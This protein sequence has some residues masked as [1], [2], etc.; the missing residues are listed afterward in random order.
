[1]EI[2]IQLVGHELFGRPLNFS[3][4]AVYVPEDGASGSTEGAVVSPEGA[5]GEQEAPCGS[6]L[7]HAKGLVSREPSIAHHEPNDCPEGA[8]GEQEAPCGS[9][10]QPAKGLVSREPSITHHEPNDC[11]EGAAGSTEGAGCPM[12][13]PAEWAELRR[14]AL[15]HKV[16]TFVWDSAQ[17]L[18][19]V[20]DSF[21]D[22]E[23]G[24]V[25]NGLDADEKMRWVAAVTKIEQDYAHLYKLAAAVT[26]TL[27]NDGFRFR[28]LKGIALAQTYPVPSHRKFG[29]LDIYFPERIDEAETVLCRKFGSAVVKGLNHHDTMKVAGV[30]LELHRHF[31]NLSKYSS[32]RL[33]QK[34]LDKLYEGTY[35]LDK[36]L[37]QGKVA[38]GC[39]AKRTADL[40]FILRHAGAHFVSGE[41]SLMNLTDVGR[42]LMTYDTEIDYSKIRSI[43]SSCGFERWWDVVLSI[44]VQRIGFTLPQRLA[45]S[46]RIE[47]QNKG[48]TVRQAGMSPERQNHPVQSQS[49]MNGTQPAMADALVN[50]VMADVLDPKFIS[51]ERSSKGIG[52]LTYWFFSSRWKKRLVFANDS[53]AAVFFRTIIFWFRRHL[54]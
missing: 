6:P 24:V 48:A 32:N 27:K 35:S 9:P 19:W 36:T 45:D 18:G 12:K 2:M 47:S 7:Q 39:S 1:M 25:V 52:T 41:L 11:L 4:S 31:F 21:A 50:K 8:A 13:N 16:A 44:L 46:L 14:L 38:E 28:L 43:A 20:R 49:A 23:D 34:E 17:K 42:F 22:L 40:A 29:D 33:I 30:E 15:K 26:T 51:R 10:L 3:D 54:N 53:T 5:A 37:V